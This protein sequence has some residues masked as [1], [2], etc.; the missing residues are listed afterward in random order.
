MSRTTGLGWISTRPSG[1]SQDKL[2]A[3]ISLLVR[4]DGG[5]VLKAARYSLTG[6]DVPLS[7]VRGLG[8]WIPYGFAMPASRGGG[9]K[10]PRGRV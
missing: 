4:Q 8:W 5:S 9:P 7:A 3:A 6:G 1:K 10:Y 2:Q